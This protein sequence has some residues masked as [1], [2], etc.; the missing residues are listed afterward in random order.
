[1]IPSP[2]EE[3]LDDEVDGAEGD[4]LLVVLVGLLVVLVLVLVRLVV[5]ALVD[6]LDEELDR[7]TGLPD[8]PGKGLDES[9]VGVGVLG[10][11]SPAVLELEL[12][13]ALV[14]GPADDAAAAAPFKSGRCASRFA[15]PACPFRA[16]SAP[17]AAAPAASPSRAAAS[18]LFRSD[19]WCRCSPAAT[20]PLT[21]STLVT[22]AAVL[23]LPLALFIL[24]GLAWLA[25]CLPEPDMP[26]KGGLP[27]SFASWARGMGCP[28]FERPREACRE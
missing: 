22:A 12:E 21:A 9:E 24:P 23:T 11:G 18:V 26:D 20:P 19:S 4:V 6:E 14:P 10:C 16:A 13:S 15:P 3:E 8:A 27:P 17:A 5:G 28:S 25:T 1:M 7:E 2:T